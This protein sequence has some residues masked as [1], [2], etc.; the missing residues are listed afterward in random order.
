LRLFLVYKQKFFENLINLSIP[1]CE[2]TYEATNPE[3]PQ[4]IAIKDDEE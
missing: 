1:F 3:N 2:G 4:L